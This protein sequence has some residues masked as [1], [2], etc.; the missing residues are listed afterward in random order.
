MDES[1]ISLFSNPRLAMHVR[2]GL[3][4]VKPVWK[5][6]KKKNGLK[7]GF[8]K[9]FLYVCFYVWTFLKHWCIKCCHKK[10]KIALPA[11]EN[12]F[13]KELHIMYRLAKLEAGEIAVTGFI[14]SN[15]CPVSK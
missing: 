14:V 10:Q 2:G 6:K 11:T 9:G 4:V 1:E 5:K 13:A 3:I 7:F 8:Y 12:C 15:R